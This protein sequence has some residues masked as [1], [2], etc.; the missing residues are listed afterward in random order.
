MKNRTLLTLLYGLGLLL[1]LCSSLLPATV[2]PYLS[3]LA[4]LVPLVIGLFLFRQKNGARILALE[5]KDPQGR[6][7]AYL[8]FPIILLGIIGISALFGWLFSL[9]GIE[10]T[11]TLSYPLPAALIFYAAVPALLEEGLYRYLPL[12]ALQD[13]SRGAALIF[14]S[15]AFA[16]AHLSLISLPYALFAG[17]GLFTVNLLAKSLWPSVLLHLLNNVLGVLFLFYPDS[18]PLSL[19]V[20]LTL[21]VLSVIAAVLI[22]RKREVLVRF[23]AELREDAPTPIFTFD[24]I[25]FLILTF[26]LSLIQL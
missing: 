5:G 20:I 18:L 7:L 1:L 22:A 19:V 6:T 26:C 15:L 23:L 13:E 2:R 21:A 3:P 14:S 10:S 24:L 17:V 8:L 11:T 4:L 16:F 25:A 9:V 12:L